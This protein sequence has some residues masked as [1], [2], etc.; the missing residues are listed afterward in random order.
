MP[1]PY[2]SPLA[3]SLAEDVLER[4]LRYTRIDTQS[5]RERTQSP[6]TPGQLDLAR[7]LVDELNAIGL[8]DVELAGQLGQRGGRLALDVCPVRRPRRLEPPGV[9]VVAQIGRRAEL[10]PVLVDDPVRGEQLA[11]PRLAHPRPA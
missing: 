3:A 10:P 8:E 11:E 5:A 1:A 9:E 7:L 6:S 4:L 2:S